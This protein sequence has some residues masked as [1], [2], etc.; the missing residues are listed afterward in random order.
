MPMTDG[1]IGTEQRRCVSTTEP[2]H[3]H[4]T[5]CKS[6]QPPIVAWTSA[7]TTS[8][9]VAHALIPGAEGFVPFP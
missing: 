6:S 4:E 3:A 9:V 2:R 5:F 1:P 8:F 7:P